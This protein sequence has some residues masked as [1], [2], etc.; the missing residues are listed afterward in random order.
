MGYDLYIHTNRLPDEECY[1]RVV[2][3]TMGRVHDQRLASQ[4]TQLARA[5][6]PPGDGLVQA[7]QPAS[8]N[9]RELGRGE[10]LAARAD[11]RPVAGQAGR[12]EIVRDRAAQQ[13][14]TL[15]LRGAHTWCHTR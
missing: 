11:R 15:G 1:L 6:A 7:G 8:V 13:A 4:T 3:P 14:P 2:L 9:L 5:V 12:R 10:V